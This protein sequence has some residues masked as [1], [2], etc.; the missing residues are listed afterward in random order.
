MV[1]YPIY[2]RRSVKAGEGSI[3][4]PASKKAQ[5]SAGLYG[6]NLFI[7][8]IKTFQIENSPEFL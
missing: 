6:N 3:P 5:L 4:F 1:K 2:N 8:Y 7:E